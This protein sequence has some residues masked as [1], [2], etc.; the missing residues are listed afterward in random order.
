MHVALP[1]GSEEDIIRTREIYTDLIISCA[2]RRRMDDCIWL[3][4]DAE[5]RDLRMSPKMLQVR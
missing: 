3:L 2:R 1:P 5:S 4:N